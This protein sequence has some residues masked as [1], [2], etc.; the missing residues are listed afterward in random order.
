MSIQVVVV[1]AIILPEDAHVVEEI[2]STRVNQDEGDV[3]VSALRV[4]VLVKA[5]VAV[6]WPKLV[7]NTD[8]TM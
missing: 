6:I 2:P 5:T 8:I 4:A 1:S 7:V 3:I